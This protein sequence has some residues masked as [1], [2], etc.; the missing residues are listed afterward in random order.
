M[1]PVFS[2]DPGLFALGNIDGDPSPPVLDFLNGTI[3]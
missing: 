1:R 3:F 2:F